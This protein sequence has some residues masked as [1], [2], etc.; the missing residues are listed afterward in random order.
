VTAHTIDVEDL[1]QE[2]RKGRG[3][4]V[5]EDSLLSYDLLVLADDVESV[6]GAAGGWL[7][8]RVRAGWRVTVLAPT[9]LD[10]RPLTILGLGTAAADTL[11]ALPPG[12]RPTALAVDA[13]LA[14]RHEATRDMVLRAVDDTRTEVT[15][16]GASSLF[17]TDR[18]FRRV[19][20]RLS[21]AAR[22]FKSSALRSCGAPAAD[23]RAEAF[24]S[25]ALWYP[26]DG[27]DLELG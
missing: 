11:I 10:P 6:V 24:H 19:H 1:S 27:S 18:R 26:S 22:A 5:R 2:P 13:R 23:L 20:H 14:A 8:D 7:C 12:R 15:M 9:E 25:A 16:W 4:R 3:L 21:A 17:A